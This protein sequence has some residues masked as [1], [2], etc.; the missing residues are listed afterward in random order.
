MER[1]RDHV[2]L[3]LMNIQCI[4]WYNVY[5]V[6]TTNTNLISVFTSHALHTLDINMFIIYWTLCRRTLCLLTALYR[7]HYLDESGKNG[8][9][10]ASFYNNITV[11]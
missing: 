11:W 3:P 1:E 9:T 10:V 4:L 2:T 5:L 7:I 8:Y 6:L